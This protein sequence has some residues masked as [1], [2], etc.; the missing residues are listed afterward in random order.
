MTDPAR[1]GGRR[2]HRASDEAAHAIVD[3]VVD[4]DRARY[5]SEADALDALGVGR[6]T[7]REALR[8]LERLGVIEVRA[9]PGGGPALR[10]PDADDVASVIALWMEVSGASLRSVLDAR[11]AIEPAIARLAASHATTEQIAAMH[12]ALDEIER[13]LGDI[14]TFA[15]A[16]RRYWD[17]LATAA[18]NP[19]L[20]LLGPALRSIVNSGGFVPDEPYRVRIV[21]YL[22]VVDAAVAAGDG[23]AAEAATRA[24]DEEFTRRLEAGYPRQIEHPVPWRRVDHA[25]G[26]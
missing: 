24:L 3:A 2:S 16:Y 18:G 12:A 9:G 23:E 14:A 11:A 6:G 19:L 5:L 7:Y 21:E 25:D 22:R 20:S 8:F 13:G 10:T 17:L 26:G 15:P 1:R 4:T